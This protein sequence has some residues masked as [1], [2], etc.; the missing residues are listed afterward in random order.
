M[1]GEPSVVYNKLLMIL[2]LN[3]ILPSIIGT[4]FLNK[5]RFR[6]YM[7]YNN[8]FNAKIEPYECWYKDVLPTFEKKEQESIRNNESFLVFLIALSNYVNDKA[9]KKTKNDSLLVF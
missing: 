9:I 1:P 4:S 6:Q 2:Y 8:H 7:V 5:Y 3:N